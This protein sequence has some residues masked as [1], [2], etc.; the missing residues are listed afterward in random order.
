MRRRAKIDDNQKKIVQALRAMGA[1]VEP[2]LARIGGGVPDILVG[3]KGVN[4]LME[5]K[6]G[7][8]PKSQRKLTPDEIEWANKWRGSVYVVETIEQAI[9]I[10][11]MV[12]QVKGV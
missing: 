10:L 6:D 9:K 12:L 1:T 2:R 8:K 5:I 11:N 3:Y 4:I 7:N